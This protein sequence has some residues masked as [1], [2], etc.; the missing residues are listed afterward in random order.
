MSLEEVVFI[1]LRKKA[2]TIETASTINVR[3]A[4]VTRESEGMNTVCIWAL[5][6]PMVDGMLEVL[7]VGRGTES[8]DEGLRAG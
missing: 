1:T 6:R 5:L 7:V 4:L 8:Y 2:I 3:V